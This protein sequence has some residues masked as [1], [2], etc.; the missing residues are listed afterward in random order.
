M[1]TKL[2]SISPDA[3]L[4]KK[5]RWL[6]WLSP[7]FAFLLLFVMAV[8]RAALPMTGATQVLLMFVFMYI[9]LASSWNLIGGYTGYTD[10]GHAVF[11]G[12]GGYTAAILMSRHGDWSFWTA[13]IAA[14]VVCALFAVFVGWPTLRLRGAYFAVAMLGLFAATREVVLNLKQLTNGGEGIYFR[15]PFMADVMGRHGAYYAFLAL[16]GVAFF[17][18]LWIYRSQLGKVL[19]SIRVDE[20]AADMRGINTTR[21]KLTIFALSGAI[22]G[23]IGATYAYQNAYVEVP[24]IFDPDTTSKLIMMSMLGGMGRPWGPVV[25]AVV[26][27][28]GSRTIWA[29]FLSGHLIVLGIMLIFIVL[30]IPRGLLGLLDP[31]GRGLAW[32]VAVWQ[33]RRS[34]ATKKQTEQPVVST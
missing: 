33:T 14:A 16:A 28:I 22:T 34:A 23:I 5:W 29:S 32:Q 27:E 19:R 6:D 24:I 9:A 30:F 10:L 25:G 18:S 3:E 1:A 8:W 21:L 31:E 26:Y 15:K 7:G 2:N 11:F 12:V 4:L 20:L 17:I 13:L